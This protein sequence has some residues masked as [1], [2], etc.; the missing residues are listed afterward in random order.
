M[1]VHAPLVSAHTSILEP[2]NPTLSAH[3]DTSSG[4]ATA[5]HTTFLTPASSSLSTYTVLKAP[6][7]HGVDTVKLSCQ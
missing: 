6:L 3:S 7:Y 4:F 5:R 1:R 2:V